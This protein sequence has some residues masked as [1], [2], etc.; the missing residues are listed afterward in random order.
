MLEVPHDGRKRVV[1]E[2][3]DDG[4]EARQRPEPVAAPKR[5]SRWPWLL[6]SALLLAAA[7]SGLLWFG[8]R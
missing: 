2:E 1:V 3:E 4:F 8:A 5:V 7:I 6:V